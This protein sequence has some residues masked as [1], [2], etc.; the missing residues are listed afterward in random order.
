MNEIELKYPLCSG[1]PRPTVIQNIDEEEC[2]IIYNTAPIVESSKTAALVFNGF[3]SI[4]HFQINDNQ[5]SYLAKGYLR[6][7]LNNKKDTFIL[8][9]HNEVIEIKAQS[10]I[11]KIMSFESPEQVIEMIKE[12]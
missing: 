5:N 7:S 10:Y 9:F 6:D 4:Q 11:E 3:S 8:L 1:V 2:I 12:K